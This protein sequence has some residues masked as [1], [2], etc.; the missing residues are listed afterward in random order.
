MGIGEHVSG[1]VMGDEDDRTEQVTVD[2][3]D[4]S[5]AHVASHYGFVP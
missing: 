4:R 1:T 5:R 2:L 3:C